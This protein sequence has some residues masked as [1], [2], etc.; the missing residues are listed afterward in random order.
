MP[1]RAETYEE[2]LRRQQA[3]AA[4]GFMASARRLRWSADRLAAERERRLRDLLSWSIVHSPF[5]RDRLGGLDVDQFREADLPSLPIMTKDQLMMHFDD[6]VTDPA[7][8]FDL[9]N[10]HAEQ[11]DHD[12]YL[13]A[14]YRTVVTS[15]TTGARAAF[16]YGWDEWCDFALLATRWQAP[17]RGALPKGAVIAS[18]FAANPRHVSGAFHAFFKNTSEEAQPVVHLPASLPVPQMVEALNATG[19]A[20]LQ[21]YPSA[22]HLLACEAAAGRLSIAPL[23]VE[24]CGEQC[25]DVVRS[26][27]REAWG[28]EIYDYWGCTEGVYAFP[29]R[30]GR[31]MHIP[32]DLVI[33]EPVDGDGRPV[34]PGEQGDKLLFTSLYNRTQ[35][36]IRYEIADSTRMSSAICECGCAHRRLEILAGRTASVFIYDGGTAVHWLGMMTVLLG[37]EGL[38]EY[39][40]SQTRQGADVFVVTR[41]SC[42]L[43]RIRRALVAIMEKA[44]LDLPRVTVERVPSLD[45]M[46][47]GKLKQFEPLTG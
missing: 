7:L 44:G 42:D 12:R 5:H 33:L 40:V 30:F 11:L 13:L 14:R 31:A 1:G 36:L 37:Q 25:T 22:V 8:S 27:V 16:V 10:A 45:R 47:S 20:V 23:H 18:L 2:L 9:V 3:V 17:G 6:V 26:A 21:G 24:T 28:V 41:G 34:E 29:C 38:I 39:Q 32:D 35:P 43:E 15:G 19:P 4:D 46:W